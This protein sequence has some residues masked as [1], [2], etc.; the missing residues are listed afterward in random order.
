MS[1]VVAAPRLPGRGEPL[2]QSSPGAR[3]FTVLH[4]AAGADAD[5]DTVPERRRPQG[6]AG[7]G[8]A[9]KLWVALLGAALLAG[10]V[11]E[12]GDEAPQAAWEGAV[13]AFWQYVAQ[14]GQAVENGTAR[15]KSAEIG[16]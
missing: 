4:G 15:V 13:D 14:L 7:E 3:V 1:R 11:A 2:P 5:A 16:R 12:P 9:M 10:C 8:A 6:P